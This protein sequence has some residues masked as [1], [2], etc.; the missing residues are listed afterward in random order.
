LNQLEQKSL[1]SVEV[2]EMVEKPHNDLLKDIR[3]YSEQLGEGK[4]S[5]TD[6]FT[7]STYQSDQNKTLPCYMVTKKGCEFIANKLTG[8]K[9]AVFTAK[10]IN[11]FH[12]MEDKLKAPTSYLDILKNATL[13]VSQKVDSVNDDLQAFK[14]DMPILGIEE[15]RITSAIKKKGVS[16]LGGKDSNAYKDKSLRGKVY[17]D[18]HRELRRQF[19][20]DTYKAIKRSQTDKAVKVIEAYTLPLVLFEEVTDANAQLVM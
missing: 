6:F 19:G 2:A 10:Y 17:S 8:V 5:L 4:I 18:I 12:D 20:I 16:C 11:R 14:M 9:G 13:E 3:R 15:S 7:E 1:T